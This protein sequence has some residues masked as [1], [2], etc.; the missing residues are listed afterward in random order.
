VSDRARPLAA[1]QDARRSGKA[2]VYEEGLPASPTRTR[3]CVTVREQTR[4]ASLANLT[5]RLLTFLVVHVANHDAGSLASEQQ[6][7]GTL[8]P[9]CR[10]EDDRC[11][12]SESQHEILVHSVDQIARPLSQIATPLAATCS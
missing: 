12:V 6:G 8:H 11:V 3:H 9:A 5:R 7:G 10:R 2:S 4:A 1:R